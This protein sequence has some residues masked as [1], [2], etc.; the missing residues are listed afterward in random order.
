[1]KN[2]FQALKRVLSLI[3]VFAM[4]IGFVPAVASAAGETKTVYFQNNWKWTDVCAYTYDVATNVFIGKAWPGTQMEFVE[5][6]GTYDIYKLEIPANV[7][8][9]VING[10]KND[11]SGNRDQ[12]P[13]IKNTSIVFD[14]KCYY[15]EWNNGNAVKTFDYTPPVVEYN[16]TISL[17]DLTKTAGAAKATKGVDYTASF[18]ANEGFGLPETIEV[19]VGG[20]VISGYTYADGTLTIPGALVT[21]DISITAAGVEEPQGT[22]AYFVNSSN[23][24]TV[25]AYAWNDSGNNTWPGAAMTKTSDTVNGADV[26]SITFDT[27]YTKIIFNN[28]SSQTADLALE[29]GKYYDL[30]TNKWYNS[31]NEIPAP[32]P[33]AKDYYLIGYINGADYGCEADYANMG[34]YKF[35]DG[36]LTATFTQDSYVFLKTTDNAEWFMAESYI[37]TNS[38][39]FKNTSTGTSEKM[40]VPGGTEWEFTL[41]ENA[42]GTLTLSYAEKQE[43]GPYT[44]IFHFANTIGWSPVNLY[45]WNDDGA[46]TGSWPGAAMSKIDENG[47]LTMTVTYEAAENKGLNYIFNNGSAQTIDL[48]LAA[49]LFDET[50]KTAE[51]WIELDPTPNASGKYILKQIKDEPLDDVLLAVSPR[52]NGTSVTFEFAAPAGATSV[53][54]R[55]TFT[56]EV[57]TPV[58][59]TKNAR[60]LYTVTVD[61]LEPGIY[62]YKF[63]VNNTDW[64]TDP[65]N[66]KTNAEGNSVFTI[67]DPDAEDT[68]IVKIHIFYNRADGIY[69]QEDVDGDMDGTWN[70]SVWGDSFASQRYDF[71][72]D[73][74]DLDGNGNK[75]QMVTTIRVVGR[76]TAYVAMK[77]RM[78]TD[79]KEWFREESEARVELDNIVSGTIFLYIDSNGQD[80]KAG[81]M[82]YSVITGTDIVTANKVTSASYDYEKNTVVVT[83]LETLDGNGAELQVVDNWN[84]PDTSIVSA[85]KASGNTYTLTLNK[86]LSLNEVG[87]YKVKYDNYYYDIAMDDVYASDKFAQQYTYEGTDLGANHSVEQTT[88]K[89]WA[90]T[91]SSVNVVLYSTG[92]DREAGAA[93]RGTWE[94]TGG[95]ADDKGVWTVTVEG[96]LHGVYYTYEVTVN[97]ETT[98]AVD[99]Y[100]RAVGVNGKRGMV[101]HLDYT[102]PDGWASDTNPNPVSS[103]TD[104]V[105]YELH[106]RDFSI[107]E[108]SGI[109]E[110]NRGKYLAFTEEGTTVNGKGNTVSG[111][112]Y[113][114]Q[115]GITHLHLLPVYDYGS[116][117]ETRLNVPQFNWGY[118]PVN[119]NVPEGSYSSNPYDGT[120]RVNEFKQMVQSLHDNG[121]SVVMDVVYNHVYNADQFCFNNIVPGYFSRPNSSAS[122][123]GNDTASEREMVRKYIVDSVV[124]WA[125][126]YHID[127]FRFDLVGLLDAETINAIIT[128]VHKTHPN[129]I[130]YGEGW[131]MDSTNKEPGTEMAKQHNASKTPGFAY[132]SDSMRNNLAG[133]NGNSTGFASGA[134]NGGTIAADWM[135]NASSW[136]SVWSTNPQQVVQYVSCHDNYTLADKL[137]ISTKANDV[138]DNIIKMNNLSA[139]FYMTAQGIPFIHAGEEILREKVDENGNRAH[140]SYNA[141][142][143]VNHIKWEDVETYADNV[144]YYQGLIAFRAANPALRYASSDLVSGNVQALTTDAKLLVFRVDANGTADTEDEDILVIFNA[145]QSS[146][147][148]ELPEGEWTIYVDGEKAGTTALGTAEGTVDVAGISAMVLTTE[149]K[150]EDPKTLPATGEKTIYFTNNKGWEKVY[151]YAWTTDANGEQ[152]YL[153]GAWGGTEATFYKNNDYGQPVYQITIPASETGIEGLVFHSGKGGNDNQTVDILPGPDGTGYYPTEQNEEGKWN[154]NSWTER[155]PKL[156]DAE[157]YFLVGWINQADYAGADYKFD[158][159]GKVTVEFAVDSY[160][161]VINGDNSETYMTDGYQGAVTSAI[162]KDINKCTMTA[163]KWDKLLIPGG[164]EVTI[165]MVKNNDNTITLSYESS[166]SGVT[167]T[168]GIQNGV[169]LHCWNWSFAEIEENMEAIAEL[170]FTAV[171][172]SPIQPLKEATNLETNSVGSHWWVYYQPVDFVITTDDGNALGTKEELASMIETAHSNG[173]QVIVDVVANHLGN[174]TGNDLDNTTGNDLAELIPE[175]LRKDEYWHDINTD[176]SDWNDRYD[177]TQHCLT[178]LP[179][180][181]TA[182]D[183]IQGYVVDFLKE[184]ID[185]GVDGFRF[186]MAKSIET[187]SDD[188][189]FASDFWPTVIGGAETY[190]E[191][192][193][194]DVYMYGE[195]LDTAAISIS[196]YTQYMSVTDNSWG[197]NLRSSVAG[198]TANMAAGY[199]KAADASNLVI[200]AESHDTFANDGSSDVSE[201]AINMTWALVAAR[202]DAMGLYLAR[203]ETLTQDIG[204]ASSTGWDNEEVGEVNKFHNAFDGQDEYIDNQGDISYVER[205]TSGV[206]LVNV[207]GGACDVEVDANKIADGT[208]TDQITGNTFTVADG[209]ISGSIGDTG[210]AVVYNVTKYTITVEDT[211]GGT[212]EVSADEAEAGETVTVTVTADDG[213]ELDAIT[214]TAEDG[215]EITLT[216]LGD[217][218]YSF[219]Q[220][221]QDVTVAASFKDEAVEDRFQV[222]IGDS[223]SGKVEIST[224]NPTAGE[225]ITITVNPDEGCVVKSV[226]VKDS[227]GTQIPVTDNGNGTY[228]YTQP[229]DNVTIEVVFEANYKI[230]KGDGSSAE[231]GASDL[232]FTVNGAFAK[233]T[234][235]EVDGKEVATSNYEAKAGSTIITLKASYLKTLTEGEHTIT[236]IF[237]DGE[238]EGT[239]KLTKAKGEASNDS[240]NTGDGTNVLL[241]SVLATVSAMAM[242]VL[243][244]EKKRKAAR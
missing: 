33:V 73:T 143:Y 15:M 195:V 184:C 61:D 178:G 40:L 110:A 188:E 140:N 171:Q 133:D 25:N 78:S 179:D 49:D 216:N 161:Y 130:F 2:R 12:T 47:Y 37:S 202:A 124:Y 109:P 191:G 183:E 76:D 236:V 45:V 50:A 85:V 29:A 238:A 90:P 203:P 230:T 95:T 128:E 38:G 185:I 201:E 84:S 193:G 107:D 173:V 35:V 9:L 208:Y 174:K 104:A 135:A 58:A 209:K 88:F 206:V 69:F 22:T 46:T 66:G 231:I 34:D 186:D 39:T 205:G 28:G 119:Y 167:D 20:S 42:D 211:T 79:T 67:L 105:I 228:S 181:N 168:T 92:S 192:K 239:F 149:D 13:D 180:L 152:V 176:I 30:A 151:A 82:S 97:R 64:Y 166:V 63:V 122:G 175:Y 147:T 100:A 237:T 170:G 103:Q 226:T 52:V 134:G 14:T 93:D 242:V 4:V 118:D 19:K 32:T 21:G 138:T 125:D 91:A 177:M 155:P 24:T 164:T 198:G 81:N 87:N 23:W 225:K 222:T 232:T 169:T 48:A 121:I 7:T 111:V 36:K 31:L 99:P 74:N 83:M 51:V 137:I 75:D 197:N 117:D 41:V 80:G 141:S 54:V 221:A 101:I 145:N 241:L 156:G 8:G 96:N 148:V 219:T 146:K 200:W 53:D 59:M 189:S 215:T 98:E 150:G 114:E 70:I 163:D 123:C 113:L 62:E 56:D 190:A 182:N 160:V 115:L 194:K 120:V 102:D 214:V 157:D 94:M 172:T 108:S 187:P 196:A 218:R 153:L 144:A 116:V 199:H 17:T 11:G 213:K 126:E 244:Q 212:V 243:L 86:E 27:E 165:T 229:A 240:A 162:L 233:F 129:V 127:G 44:A 223:E 204:V 210:I 3:M 55:G 142:D 139:A 234:G 65:A 43:E 60:G 16:V 112:D 131:D 5:N 217:G 132:F 10:I 89:V 106:V 18:S 57:W 1:M 77:P 26:Y 68:N 71:T 159:D 227:A 220:P 136:G 154:V 158:E 235:I 72:P 224:S 207:K 6:D